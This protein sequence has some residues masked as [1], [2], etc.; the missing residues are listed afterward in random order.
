MRRLS[1]IAAINILNFVI[2]SG[3]LAGPSNLPP[4]A[5]YIDP[6]DQIIAR[7]GKGVPGRPFPCAR[8][9][10]EKGIAVIESMPIDKCFK[11]L[12]AQ[13]W[14]GLWRNDFEGSQF[15]AAP[16]V[17]CD[18][19]SQGDRVWLSADYVRAQSGALYSIEFVGRKTMYK[20]PY[21]HLGM[22]DQEII[23]DR[24]ISIKMVQ[25]PPPPMTKA[26]LI[27]EWR[28]CEAAGTC[29]PSKE[30]RAMMNG[31]K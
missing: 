24:V 28:R 21:G 10:N 9:K 17:V 2:T 1:G 6:T 29:I 18:Y 5:A 25:A 23:V 7:T 20:G 27:K 8:E 26:Q 4:P 3:A 15:C 13:R 16:A 19:N 14:H 22:S 11:M 12:P 31:G 30:M